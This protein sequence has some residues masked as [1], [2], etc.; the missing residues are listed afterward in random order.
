MRLAV[1]RLAE[2]P[3][4]PKA[5]QAGSVSVVVERLLLPAAVVIRVNSPDHPS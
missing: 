2:H 1:L 5:F 3:E 4:K